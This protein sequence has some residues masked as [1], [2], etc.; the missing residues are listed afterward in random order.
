MTTGDPPGDDPRVESEV[1]SVYVVDDHDH[2][3]AALIELINSS[4]EFTVT[5]WSTSAT[6]AMAEIISL[7]PGVAVV[8]SNIAGHD[9][10]EVCRQLK[11]LA[12]EVACVMVTAGVGAQW[13]SSEMAEAGVVAVVVKQVIDFPL[14]EAI[15]S[16]AAGQPRGGVNR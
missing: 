13:A 8:D 16:A 9:G 7:R 14:L 2:V 3:V 10:L 4:P 12:P 5:G 11:A 6:T 1:V 15:A